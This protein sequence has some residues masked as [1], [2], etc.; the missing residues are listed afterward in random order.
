[1]PSIKAGYLDVLK[2][3][4]VKGARRKFKGIHLVVYTVVLV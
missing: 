2:H 3:L 1:M 4:V